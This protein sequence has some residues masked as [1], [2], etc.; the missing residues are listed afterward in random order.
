MRPSSLYSFAM[1]IFILWFS[2]DSGLVSVPKIKHFLQ[3]IVT[4]TKSGGE[5]SDF[6]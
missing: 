5:S 3:E 4:R 6:I 2:S 1:G